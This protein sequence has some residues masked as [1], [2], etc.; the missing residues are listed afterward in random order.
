[1]IELDLQI[2]LGQALVA[3]RSWGAPELAEV[4]SRA[5]ELA[6][7]LNR[8]RALLF[9]LWGRFTDHWCRFDLKRARRLAGENSPEVGHTWRRA[10]LFT[11]RRMS[12]PTWRCCP[13]THWSSYGCIQSGCS[14]TL[15]GR[16]PCCLSADRA[17]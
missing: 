1:E 15:R 2:A 6:L 4:H 12:P 17:E 9:A 16:P 5:R 3:N 13:T 14:V 11:T 7:T 10:L 8:P